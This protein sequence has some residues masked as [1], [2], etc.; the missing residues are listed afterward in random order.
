MFP[1]CLFLEKLSCEHTAEME[2][3]KSL[4]HRL[5]TALHSEEFQKR[6]ERRLLEKIDQL[7]GRL[8]PLEQVRELRGEALENDTQRD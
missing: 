5:F 4:V 7:T 2:N 1:L 3:V 6:R 8:Q